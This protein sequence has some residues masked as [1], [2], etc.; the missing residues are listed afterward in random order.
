AQYNRYGADSPFLRALPNDKLT[1]LTLDDLHGLI[2]SL[3]TYRHAI[4]Y[5]GSSPMDQVEAILKQRPSSGEP[6]KPRTPYNFLSVAAPG[7]QSARSPGR[8]HGFVR[9]SADVTRALS[10]DP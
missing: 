1:A 10:R 5:T 4:T 9:R 7:G 3:L 6:L 8:V 2:K